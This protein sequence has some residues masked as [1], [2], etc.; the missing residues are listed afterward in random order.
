MTE[1][2]GEARN[3][4][5]GGSGGVVR[6]CGVGSAGVDIGSIEGVQGI[7]DIGGRCQESSTC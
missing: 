3:R 6:Q 5:A 7:G 4:D 1:G 2:T